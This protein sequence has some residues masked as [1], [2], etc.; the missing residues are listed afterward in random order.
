[1]LTET[2]QKLID[3]CR[4]A[5][6]LIE[7]GKPANT[8]PLL[9]GLFNLERTEKE[10][11]GAPKELI[12]TVGDLLGK[13]VNAANFEKFIPFCE[14]VWATGKRDFRVGLSLTLAGMASLQ[15]DRMIPY[16]FHLIESSNNW[17]ESDNI[18]GYGLE[19]L[20]RNNPE[21][22]FDKIAAYLKSANIWV[23]RGALVILYRLPMKRPDYSR[24]VLDAVEPLLSHP[25][26]QV[27]KMNKFG[28]GIMNRGDKS[29]LVKFI[30]KFAKTGNA[31]I[32]QSLQ[33][34]CWKLG[35]DVLPAVNEWLKS[36]NPKI[37]KT[38]ESI[39]KKIK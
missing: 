30:N 36:P 32:V 26:E 35:K 31:R 38:A 12:D 2:K 5:V 24:R 29:E 37:R 14:I 23:L 13:A 33:E 11:Y 34:A 8:T 21:I 15:P 6:G 1:M 7:D 19:H 25:D 18:G 3:G 28:I 22:Y 39:I 9:Q 4:E 27:Y 16:V 17:E 10:M 20:A